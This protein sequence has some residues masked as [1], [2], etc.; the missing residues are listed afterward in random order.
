[1]PSE[2]RALHPRLFLTVR[3]GADS[4]GCCLTGPDRP[5]AEFNK[6]NRNDSHVLGARFLRGAGS[7]GFSSNSFSLKRQ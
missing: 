4:L 2:P 5:E 7:G 1:M 6:I 3:D